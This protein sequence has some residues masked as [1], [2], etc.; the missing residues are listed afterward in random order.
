[1]QQ[2]SI[3]QDFEGE[4]AVIGAIMED[5]SRLSEVAAIISPNAFHT[6]AHQ[7]VFR[8]M[9]ELEDKKSPFDEITIT[10]QLKSLSQLE[11][12]GG[13]AYLYELRECNPTIGNI[14][15]YA[16]IIRE[17]ATARDLIALAMDLGRKCK[18][19]EQNINELLIDAD[20]KISNII[21]SRT[22]KSLV[23]IKKTL[24]NVYQDLEK[25]SASPGDIFG[26]PTGYVD[27]DKMIG[28]LNAPDLILIAGRP[29]MG[30]TAFALNIASYIATRHTKKAIPF[31]TREMSNEQLATRMLI[32]EGKIDSGK[33]KTGAFEQEDWD[34]L[35]YATD[36][37]SVSNIFFDSKTSNVHNLVHEVKGLGKRHKEGVGAVFV[38]YVQL[39][40]GKTNSNREQEVAEISRSL[41]NLALDLEIPVIALSQLNRECEKR[42]DKRPMLSDLRESGSL[43]QDPDIII[44][45]YRDEVYDQETPDK[46]IAEAIIRKNRNGSLKTVRLQFTGKYTKFANLSIQEN[47]YGV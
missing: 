31:F 43:E 4:Q 47:P 36:Q 39:L 34:R 8:A 17:H 37:L 32:S 21:Q 22:S 10:D 26:I 15:F 23:H 5:N 33:F 13:S 38:D 27:L 1:M 2:S 35:A 7:H 41:K 30:K 18:D 28:G 45:L 44:C 16:K 40:R 14:V 3:P 25:K 42:S 12:I 9:I 11:E 20:T 46:G 24:R 29:S 6:I 19:P